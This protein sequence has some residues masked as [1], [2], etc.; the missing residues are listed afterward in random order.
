M[1]SATIQK[2]LQEGRDTIT[3]MH[4]M[5]NEHR[6]L[7]READ[8]SGDLETEYRAHN[9]LKYYR[10]QIAQRVVIQKELKKLLKN[11]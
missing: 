9:L 11:A 8:E 5:V 10:K 6:Q 4:I 7:K 3:F 2:L 1:K